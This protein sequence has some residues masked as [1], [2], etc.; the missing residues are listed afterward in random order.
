MIK[1]HPDSTFRAN[2]SV[3]D[4]EAMAMF[5]RALGNDWAVTGVWPNNCVLAGHT[6]QVA[7]GL[8]GESANSPAL[9]GEVAQMA[10]NA[11]INAPY[12]IVNGSGANTLSAGG[13]LFT[14]NQPSGGNGT[15]FPENIVGAVQTASA[16]SITILPTKA[17]IGY[18]PTATSQTPVS[19]GFEPSV[20]PIGAAALDGSLQGASATAIVDCNDLVAVIDVTAAT[21]TAADTLNQTGQ[22]ASTALPAG[23]SPP[24]N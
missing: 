15:V 1:G 23:F 20:T 8:T 2:S 16:N 11:A 24:F 3:T 7:N 4:A 22:A 9:R 18:N 10:Y 19:Y 17:G 14:K 13:G 21:Q 5:V 12:T 6:Y